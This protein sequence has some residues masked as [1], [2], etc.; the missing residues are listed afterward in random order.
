M[1]KLTARIM[2]PENPIKDQSLIDYPQLFP[3]KVIGKK[4][5][6]L[7]CTVTKIVKNKYPDFNAETIEIRSSQKGK[8][9]SITCTVLVESRTRLDLIYRE[10]SSLPTVVMVL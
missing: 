6:N 10:L 1:P 8:Y 3:I 4:N 2:E 7:I 9:I 5:K